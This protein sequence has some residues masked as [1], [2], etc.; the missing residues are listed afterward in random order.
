MDGP[1]ILSMKG[2]SKEY[3]GN[4]VLKG[5]DLV[6]RPGEIHALVGENG[7]GKSTLMNILFGMPVI[8]TTGGF[9]GEVEIAG[10]KVAIMNP[11]EAMDHGI[12][13]VHQEFMLIPD[14][15]IAENIK[16]GREIGIPT[17]FSKFLGPSMDVLDQEA[18]SRDARK[19]LA[20]IGMN[21]EDYVKVA[22][23]PIGYKQF[24]EIAREIDKTGIKL[25]VFDEPTAVL[26]ESEAER[27][28][29][30]MKLITDQGI[31]IIFITH[32]LDEV[33][34]VADSL[35]ILRD[36]ELVDRA[37]T[38]DITMVEI[39]AKMI[40]RKV[41]RL[42]DV[43][44]T[45]PEL[46]EETMALEMRN[47]SVDM[48]GEQVKDMDVSIRK[49]EIFGFGGL[50]GQGKIGIINGIMGLFPA[51]GE[52]FV[53]GEKLR[54]ERL[55]EALS[56]DVAFVSEDRRGV[57]L[58]LNESIERNIIFSAMQ[59]HNQFLRRLG[60]IK[61][62]NRSKAKKHT[63]DMI[64]LLDIRC[65]GPQQKTGSLSGGN[66]QKVCLAR[67]LTI[68]PK[69][70][71]VAE[72]TR[73]IDIGAKKLVL[74]H[75][76]KINLEQGMTIIIISSELVELR[77]ICDRIGIVAE[78]KVAEIL[79]PDASDAAFGLAMSGVAL[80]DVEGEVDHE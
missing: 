68:E 33:M 53:F 13:M 57:G 69:I 42:I 7:A 47:F 30:I 37:E 49:G 72:P 55:G 25:L 31:A 77:S 12:G 51:E 56:H 52:L 65:T 32:R 23:L 73:G 6:V 2:I 60:P 76:V 59:V 64:K 3:F 44:E 27:L 28:L 62:I 48:A 70:L 46:D 22:G 79:P 71:I 61:M 29:E 58:L 63:L 20:R 11:H 66:Q 35:T 74:E 80:N 15:T 14:F 9:S 10:E 21:I 5:V 38:K 19:S 17:I 40:G 34:T 8:H 1:P 36:G 41:E 18:M 75:L 54:L 50:A 4:Q 39:A 45:R 78:G 67:A 43:A 24:V 16:V 26:T